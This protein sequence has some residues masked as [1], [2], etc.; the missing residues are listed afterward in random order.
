MPSI[1]SWAY[2]GSARRYWDFLY[3]GKIERLERQLHHY[4][5]GINAIPILDAYR[6]NPRDLYLL[7]IGYGGS[8]GAITGIDR[9]GCASA[10]FHSFPD[11]ME[12]DP[13]TGD[14]GPNF[15][16]HAWTSGSYLVHDDEFGWLAFGG[17]LTLDRN[18]VSLQPLD[19][20]RQRVYIAPLGLWL[21]LDSGRFDRVN[22]DAENNAL[23]LQLSPADPAT[24]AALLRIEQTAPIA[25]IG[26]VHLEGV[27]A[28]VRGGYSIPLGALATTVRLHAE[29]VPEGK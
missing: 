29:S 26:K 25:G 21:T 13:Y 2:N 6:R 8:M 11:R 7:R 17:N 20:F 18:H 5:S 19:S 16:G 9:Q 10:A 28:Q 15:F 22:Y 14:Y 3:G 4:G 1:P 27:Y 12:F 23:E 24:S